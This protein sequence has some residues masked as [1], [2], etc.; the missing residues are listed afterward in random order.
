MAA[1]ALPHAV[2]AKICERGQAGLSGHEIAREMKISQ[3]VVCKYLKIPLPKLSD[4]P[5]SWAEDYVPFAIDGG[6]RALLL[7]DVHIPFHVTAAVEAAVTAGKKQNC[8]VVILGGDALDFHGVSRYDHDGTKLTYQQEIEYGVQFFTYLRKQFPKARIVFKEGNHEERLSKYILSRAPVL[9]GLEKTS[10][11]ALLELSD[12]GIEH[13]GEQ[14]VVHAGKLRIIHGHEYGGSTNAPVNAARWLMLRARKP[15]VMGHLHHT[16][17]QIE[18][19][20]D[21]DQL[22]SWSVGCLCGL[23]PRYRRLNARWNHG[24]AVV[25][26]AKNGSFELDNR[27]IM[28]GKVV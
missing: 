3:S 9:F 2:H 11:P 6:Y 20:I 28:N 10:L 14:R 27:R 22:A 24:F 15:A 4:L 21:G 16:S 17:E 12:R 23:S 18:A 8:N 26:V 25:E 13:V 19:N 5:V 1:H 7:Y